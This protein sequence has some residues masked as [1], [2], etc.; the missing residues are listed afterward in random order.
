MTLFIENVSTVDATDI[1]ESA[2]T[3]VCHHTT[4]LCYVIQASSNV[5]KRDTAH[6]SLCVMIYST[7]HSVLQTYRMSAYGSYNS[8]SS[9]S[10]VTLKT[11]RCE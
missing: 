5:C 10:I 4:F 3:S 11:D 1:H 8:T 7:F 2:D 6:D 9:V